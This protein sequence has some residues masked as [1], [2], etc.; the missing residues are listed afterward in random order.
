VDTAVQVDELAI[1]SRQE[2]NNMTRLNPEAFSN[3]R[4]SSPTSV[5]KRP[6][7]LSSEEGFVYCESLYDTESLLSVKENDDYST[8]EIF[9]DED[10][11]WQNGK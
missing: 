11:L 4:T 9:A 10:V 6:R 8:I 3:L 1:S 2:A 5:C 7:A